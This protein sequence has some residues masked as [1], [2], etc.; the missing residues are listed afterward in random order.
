MD[1]KMTDVWHKLSKIDV[2]EHKKEKTY[3]RGNHT[4]RLSYLSWAWA[5]GALKK[6][7]PSATYEVHADKVYPD[8]TV[9]V[10]ISVTVDGLTHM[11]WLPVMDN[12]NN[13]IVGPT[14][15]DIS[16]SRM[17]C[18]AKAVAMHGLGHYIYAGEDIPD[19]DDEKVQSNKIQEPEPEPEKTSDD[20]SHHSEGDINEGGFK[21]GPRDQKIGTMIN[22]FAWKPEDRKPR[23]FYYWDDWATVCCA[24]I[25][26]AQHLSEKKLT[27]FVKANSAVIKL[28]EKQ[29]STSYESVRDKVK[30]KREELKEKS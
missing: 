3:Q 2:N 15:K 30:A 8:N 4:V 27:E 16:D 25:D 29:S 7:F 23:S 20:D 9:E 17:R 22:T 24:W 13:S 10:R 1:Q 11:M 6:E 21:V 14:S 26:A 5:W 19:M 12:R 28:A 18:L